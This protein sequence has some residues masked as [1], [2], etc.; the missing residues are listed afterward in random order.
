MN[1]LPLAIPVCLIVLFSCTGKY[2]SDVQEATVGEVSVST[3]SQNGDT[4]KIDLDASSIRWKGTKLRATR[5]HEG[6]V[7]LRQAYLLAKGR[8]ITGGNMVA[9][10]Q[11][12][13]A[14]DI[15]AHETEAERN[16]NE[17]L[18]GSDFF[19]VERY[20]EAGFRIMGVTYRAGSSLDITG[21]LTI[22]GVTKSIA[23]GASDRDSIFSATFRF[24]RFLWGITYEGNLAE[25]TLIDRDIELTVELKIE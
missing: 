11:T 24:D 7:R 3:G 9:D 6:T 18:R 16:L 13:R 25:R 21:N 14:M 2:R 20:P 22:K 10:M 17:H 19:D 8:R 12:L 15:P 5:K 1:S 23:F 4:L